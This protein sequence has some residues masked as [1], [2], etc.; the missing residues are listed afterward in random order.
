MI[1]TI[2]ATKDASQVRVNPGC[3][4]PS[5]FD[6]NVAGNCYG[7]VWRHTYYTIW[8]KHPHVEWRA[9]M[10]EPH[11]VLKAKENGHWSE[12]ASIV[13]AITEAFVEFVRGDWL[14]SEEYCAISLKLFGNND[15]FRRVRQEMREAE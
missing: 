1:M 3:L 4:E 14:E 8:D 2:A 13:E 9:V 10:A 5:S 11:T 6:I 7:M 12:G 15:I